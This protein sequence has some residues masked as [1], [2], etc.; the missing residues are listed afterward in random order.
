MTPAM[1]SSPQMT[2][3]GSTSV[4]SVRGRALFS[5]NTATQSS[6]PSMAALRRASKASSWALSWSIT[7]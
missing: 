3:S 6:R 2:L 4:S 1:F 7:D 5:E